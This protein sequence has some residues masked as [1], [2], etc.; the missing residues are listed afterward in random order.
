MLKIIKDKNISLYSLAFGLFFVFLG[1]ILG[2]FGAHGLNGKIPDALLETFNTGV[3]YQV[4]HGLGLLAL[5]SLQIQLREV[6]KFSKCFQFLILGVFF[7]SFNC[8]FYA[9]SGN[10]AFAMIIPIGGIL[11]LIGWGLALYHVLFLI[12]SLRNEQK[13]Q[14]KSEE[15]F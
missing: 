9:L 4:I 13:N 5:S 1:V 3:H 10:K 15:A 6:L 12:L 7:F 8:Y 11:F 14:I 2:A